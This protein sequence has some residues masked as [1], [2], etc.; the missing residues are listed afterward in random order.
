MLVDVAGRVAKATK[1]WEEAVVSD[2]LDGELAAEFEPLRAFTP[3]GGGNDWAHMGVV[4]AAAI[5]AGVVVGFDEGGGGVEEIGV[6]GGEVE[7]RDAGFGEEDEAL[8]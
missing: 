1:G 2:D 6:D 5:V 4:A 3:A 7:E 8:V